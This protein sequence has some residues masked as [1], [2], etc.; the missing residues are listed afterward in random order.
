MLLLI[1]YLH[2]VL[3]DNFFRHPPLDFLQITILSLFFIVRRMYVQNYHNLYQILDQSN[4]RLITQNE[5]PIALFIFYV[6][7]KPRF[8]DSNITQILITLINQ[9]GPITII[10]YVHKHIGYNKQ[11]NICPVFRFRP[12]DIPFTSQ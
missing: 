1:W 7:L 3:G 12:I 8:L 5:L 11:C 6:D 4:I 2:D 9:I 10:Y